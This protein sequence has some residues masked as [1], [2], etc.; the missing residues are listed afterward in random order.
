M[1]FSV[2]SFLFLSNNLQQANVHYYKRIFLLRRIFFLGKWFFCTNMAFL[3]VVSH[4]S[5][6][7]GK[8]KFF[9]GEDGKTP[10]I[11]QHFEIYH[12]YT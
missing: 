4:S 2:H 6:N 7:L 3:F 10:K 5:L 9:H 1:N 8:L 12:L 11:L